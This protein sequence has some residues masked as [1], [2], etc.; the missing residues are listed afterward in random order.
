M[1]VVPLYAFTTMD[2]VD[3]DPGEGRPDEQ[4]GSTFLLVGS[5][6]RSADRVEGDRGRTDTILLLHSGAGPSILMSIPRDSIVEVP[7]YGSTKINAAYSYGGAELLTQAVE[8]NT[9]IRVDDY[10]EIGFDGL[11]DVVDAVGGIEICPK[12]AIEDRDSR[13]DVEA[14]CQ[15]ADGD[16]ALAYSRVRK[17]YGDGDIQRVQ[18]QREVMAGIAS[19]VVSP[20]TFVNPIRYWG[21]NTGAAASVRIGEDTNPYGVAKFA[22]ALRGAMGA[23]GLSCT[24]PL[25]DFSVRWDPE[26]SQQMF[27]AISGDRTGSIG[28]LCTEDGLPAG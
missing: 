15:N 19:S 8:L 14:G 20:W 5:D 21:V 16:T 11:K 27:E 22:L 23:D 17:A 12:E 18:N 4:R 2:T 28:E 25:A 13:L 7:G 26:R 24:V 6:S 1:V 9:G 10:V 3:A